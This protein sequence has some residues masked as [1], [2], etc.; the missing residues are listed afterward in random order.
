[1]GDEVY[2]NNLDRPAKVIVLADN[3]RSYLVE[4]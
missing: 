3:D 2:I 1:M 4:G